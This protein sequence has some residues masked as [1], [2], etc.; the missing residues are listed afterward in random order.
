MPWCEGCHYQA[1]SFFLSSAC[2]LASAFVGLLDKISLILGLAALRRCTTVGIELGQGRTGR[3]EGFVGDQGNPFLYT[4][5]HIKNKYQLLLFPHNL[6]G[7][8][9]GNEQL[10]MLFQGFIH[11]LLQMASKCPKHVQHGP[12]WPLTLL[13][14]TKE[15]SCVFAL[16]QQ[17]TTASQLWSP[18]ELLFSGQGLS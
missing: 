3:E 5:Y 14:N 13:S 16:V 8:L 6:K 15:R 12:T 2:V 4:W 11:R 1:Q 10:L 9:R 18:R 7:R 17:F